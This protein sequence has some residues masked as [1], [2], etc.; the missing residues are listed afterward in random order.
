MLNVIGSIPLMH[1][2]AHVCVVPFVFF[3]YTGIDINN[4]MYN[5][6]YIHVL[7]ILCTVT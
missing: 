3:K 1:M 5:I 6:I 2:A 4:T 7:G